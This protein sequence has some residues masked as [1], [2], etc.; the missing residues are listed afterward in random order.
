MKHIAINAS[1]FGKADEK[2]V[3][4]KVIAENPEMKA[5]IR[6][7]IALV[8]ECI[9]EFEAMSEEQKKELMSK[10]TVE[11]RVHEKG[12]G[13]PPLPNAEKGK[14]IMRFAPNPNGPPTLGSARG[15]IINSE[16]CKCTTD[17]HHKIRRYRP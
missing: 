8:R 13:L 3:I 7:V 10:Y 15:I 16:Y 1:K 6:D 14:V 2:A 12:I 17:I 4:G 9:K 11:R 5:K